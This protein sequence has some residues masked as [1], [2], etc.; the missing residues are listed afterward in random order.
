M[1]RADRRGGTDRRRLWLPLLVVLALGVVAGG[2]VLLVGGAGHATAAA[3]NSRATAPQPG[4]QL[5]ESPYG[6]PDT[7]LNRTVPPRL[8][9]PLPASGWHAPA[10]PLKL[11][12]LF[13]S[14]FHGYLVITYRP[15]LSQA[16]RTRLRT[17]VLAHTD[18]RIVGAP[19]ATP[20][21]P[22]LDLVEW[23]WQLRCADAVPSISQVDRFAAHRL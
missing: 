8:H 6:Y 9:P 17:W 12:M 7:Y 23:G 4:C 22:L 21:A 20:G 16:A 19:D 14:V 11:D 2:L 10:D 13:H 1:P 18:E 5:S 3:R 15:D